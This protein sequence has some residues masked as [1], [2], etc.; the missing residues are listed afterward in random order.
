[1][2][3]SKHIHVVIFGIGNVGSTLIQQIIIAQSN[4]QLKHQLQIEIPIITNSK[5]AFYNENGIENSW[6]IDFEKF[7]E[8]YKIEDIIQ[9][10]KAKKFKNVIAIDATAS[11][12]FV[13]N[14]VPLIENGFHI[15]SANKVANTLSYDFYEALRQSLRKHNKSFLYETNVG[16]GLP[17]IETIKNLYNSGEHIAK[18][19]GVFSGSLSYIFNEYSESDVS[20][21]KVLSQASKLGLT[22]PDAREDLSGNDVARKLLIL[23]RELNLKTEFQQV[24]IESLVPKKL[25]G[26]TNV[27]QFN[28]RVKELDLPFQKR[29]TALSKNQVLRY[30]GELDVVKQTLEVKLITE[31]KQSPIGQLKGADSIF[32]IFTE[33]YGEKP[34]VIQGAGA[35]KAVTA[36]GLF[37]DIIKLSNNLN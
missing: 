36:R 27:Q 14:Y 23:A 12:D 6:L 4:L 13:Q 7:S 21:S 20:F 16:A 37:S 31:Q 9:F 29:K 17:I 8:P 1:M 24:K 22:E 18:I 3:N 26:K 30:V 28:A 25:N 19:R 33:S 5:L 10:I 11:V 2:S 34:F 32:E 35:G 15:V